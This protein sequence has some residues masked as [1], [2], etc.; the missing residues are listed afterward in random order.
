M[1]DKILKGLFRTLAQVEEIRELD[2]SNEYDQ[3]EI[4]RQYLYATNF[5][6]PE[7]IEEEIQDWSQTRI[8]LGQKAQSV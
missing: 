8:D 3:A 4:A 1:V 2:P 7:E 6:T 5:G